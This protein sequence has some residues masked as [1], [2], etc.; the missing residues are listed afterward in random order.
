MGD[1]L[2]RIARTSAHSFDSWSDFATHADPA[3]YPQD[4]VFENAVNAVI[5]GDLATLNACES[6]RDSGGATR[7]ASRD[8]Q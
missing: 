2:D 8:R 1:D 5:T 3:N 7:R 4:S 6:I